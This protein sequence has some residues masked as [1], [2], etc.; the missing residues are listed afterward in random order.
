MHSVKDFMGVDFIFSISYLLF[1]PFHG[2]LFV[3]ILYAIVPKAQ[4][5]DLTP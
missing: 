3:I 5:S 2:V 1:L 4:T